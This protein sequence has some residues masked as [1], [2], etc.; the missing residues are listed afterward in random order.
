MTIL[1]PEALA[2]L[3]AFT[4][5]SHDQQTSV[6]Q[7]VW[8]CDQK[9]GMQKV[10]MPDGAEAYAYPGPGKSFCWGL[11]AAESGICIARGV[12]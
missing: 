10:S 6:M 1:P 3:K 2:T 4:E 11:N 12:M 9:G 5:L 7:A 8:L